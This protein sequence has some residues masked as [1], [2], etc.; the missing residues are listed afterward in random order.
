M[1]EKQQMACYAWNIAL[2]E[3]EWMVNESTDKSV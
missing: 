1:L 2:G 3:D